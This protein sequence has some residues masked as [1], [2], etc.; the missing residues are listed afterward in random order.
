M[1]EVKDNI[2]WVG[3]SDW[4]LRKFHG[5]E[6]STHRG[7]SY[8][9]Y[10]I[11][12]EKT[13]LVDTVWNPYKEEFVENLEKEVGLENIDYIVINHSEPDHAGSLGLLMSKIPNTPIYCTKSG[14]E[15]IKK[16]FHEDWNFKIV[17]TGDKINIGQTDLTFI[18]MKMIHWP[19]SMMTYVNKA[20]VV[21][22]NDAFGQHYCTSSLFNDE[23]DNCELYQEAIK[24]YANIVAPFSMMV[25]KKVEEIK[26]LNLEIDIIAPSHGV[27]WRK[28]PLQIVEKYYDWA[29]DYHEEFVSI[30]YDTMYNAT[31]MM[32]DSIAEGLRKHGIVSKLY[33]A[34]VTDRNDLITEIFKSKGVVIGS[35]TVNNGVL[36]AIGGLIEEI[37]GLKLKRKFAG[38]FGTYGWSGESGKIISQ[39]LKSAGLNVIGEPIMFKYK[40]TEDELKECVEFGETIAKAMKNS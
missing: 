17:K 19:D 25:K 5:N 28:D 2:F 11:K 39:T 40:P 21:L 33:N 8:N 10:L 24:Y 29:C 36:A 31:K 9:A 30:V 34:S 1:I 32:A 7:S 26:A 27:I 6:L 38:A 15:I 14:A 22:S 4:D 13:V 3:K 23:V 35:C 16:H 20:K 12:D 18:E 37:K